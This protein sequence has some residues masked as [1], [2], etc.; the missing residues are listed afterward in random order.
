MVP[1]YCT[2]SEHGREKGDERIEGPKSVPVGSANFRSPFGCG[3]RLREGRMEGEC[4]GERGESTMSMR[5]SR[6]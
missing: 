3:R 4:E 6:V 2:S 5:A 1:G